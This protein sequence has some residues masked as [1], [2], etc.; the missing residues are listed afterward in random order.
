MPAVPEGKGIVALEQVAFGFVF[1]LAL[2]AD[3]AKR[4]RRNDNAARKVVEIQRLSIAGLED[5]FNC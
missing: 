2:P 5:V 3:H 4:Q 1:I